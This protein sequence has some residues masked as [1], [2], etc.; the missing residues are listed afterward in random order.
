MILLEDRLFEHKDIH[1]EQSLR[2]RSTEIEERPQRGRNAQRAA[3]CRFSLFFGHVS[4]TLDP[5]F[6]GLV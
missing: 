4:T 5:M 6:A 2:L 1:C 3:A